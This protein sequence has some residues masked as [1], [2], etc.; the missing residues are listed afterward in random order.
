M[1]N[2]DNLFIKLQLEKDQHTGR[3]FLQVFFDRNAP[4][5]AIQNELISWN[6]T[7][8]EL[9]FIQETFELITRQQVP[10]PPPPTKDYSS[11]V[12]TVESTEFETLDDTVVQPVTADTVFEQSEEPPQTSAQLQTELKKKP[13]EMFRQADEDTIDKVLLDKIKKNEL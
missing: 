10:P 7:Q 3:L 1:G 5:I 6:P 13:I 12:Q 11:T 8:A 9:S 4:N 2:K